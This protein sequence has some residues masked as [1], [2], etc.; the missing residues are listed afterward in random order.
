M[1]KIK[2]N[3][4]IIIP[5]ILFIVLVLTIIV[6]F[7]LKNDNKISNSVN[8]IGNKS[9]EEIE[10][11]ILNI[12][13]YNAELEVTVESNK[14]TNKYLLE[15]QYSANSFKQVV[16]EPSNIEGLEIIYENNNLKINN[17]KLNLSNIYEN[18]NYIAGNF[19]SLDSFIEDYKKEKESQ[20]KNYAI[21]SENN[22]VIMEVKLSNGN[23]YASYKKLYIDRNTGNIAKL[24]IQDINKKNL[25]YI[26][27]SKIEI[28]S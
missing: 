28:N 20:S 14:N 11:Y 1:G 2:I 21:K 8:N 25:V 24:V 23:K 12:S 15:Q 4:K 7:L 27:Y 5:I 22:Y 3:K 19:L 13:S 10:K 18:Y 26:L 9:L 17:T 6:I 16:R